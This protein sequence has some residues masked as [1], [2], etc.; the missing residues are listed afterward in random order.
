MVD[1]FVQQL[2]FEFE[3]SL[4][5]ELTYFI[6]FKVKQ[7]KYGIFVS[8]RKYAKTLSRSLVL[9]IQGI[10]ALLMSLM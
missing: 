6:G 10:N 1:H 9:K 2:Q 5:G 7:I 3:M 4:V 8:Q